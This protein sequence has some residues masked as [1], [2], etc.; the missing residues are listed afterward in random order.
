MGTNVIHS[1]WLCVSVSVPLIDR[2][3]CCLRVSS[4]LMILNCRTP[5]YIVPP[6]SVIPTL[7]ATVCLSFS[8]L[9]EHFVYWPSSYYYWHWSVLLTARS[10]LALPTQNCWPVTVTWWLLGFF[11]DVSQCCAD[12]GDLFFP[13]L[14]VYASCSS[15]IRYIIYTL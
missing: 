7:I 9:V 12:T 8:E 5:S 4:T 15:S 3:S 10:A 2:K 6:F 11:T 14:S 1:L 13:L